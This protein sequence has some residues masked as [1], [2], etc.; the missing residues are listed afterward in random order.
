MFFELSDIIFSE[1]KM[2]TG[3]ITQQEGIEETTLFIIEN[4]FGR[5][6]HRHLSQILDYMANTK[7]NNGPVCKYAL[8][9]SE[10][11]NFP[12]R[13]TIDWLNN[14]LP[15][16]L[17]VI[18]INSQITKTV[19][20]NEYWELIFK[21]VQKPDNLKIENENLKVTLVVSTDSVELQEIAS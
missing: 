4:Q 11:Q 19:D 14:Y 13:N 5:A 2:L 17:M 6:D 9:I 16:K 20:N 3:V 21:I 10:L 7:F 18:Q 15:V 8:W 1:K 12:K